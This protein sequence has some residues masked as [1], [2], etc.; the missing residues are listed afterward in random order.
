MRVSIAIALS[1]VVFGCVGEDAVDCKP[2]VKFSGGSVYEFDLTPLCRGISEN[3]YQCSDKDNNTYFFNICGKVNILGFHYECQGTA[4]CQ[5]ST[6]GEYKN[7]GSLQTQRFEPDYETDAGQGVIVRYENGTACRNGQSR[8]TA[9]FIEC[10]KD[11]EDPAIQQ[12]EVDY[13]SYSIHMKSKYGCG[14][15]IKDGS[16]RANTLRASAAL[17]ILSLCFLLL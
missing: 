14:K 3:D 9:I 17:I 2:E 8:N 15:K 11:A 6:S 10:D 13:C 7:A 1:V 5:V 4:V 16:S 12:A